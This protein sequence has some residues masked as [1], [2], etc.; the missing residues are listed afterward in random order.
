MLLMSTP[1]VSAS[2]WGATVNP[3]GLFSTARL[4]RDCFCVVT[5]LPALVEWLRRDLAQRGYDWRIIETHP[6]L[7]SELAVFVSRMHIERMQSL[8][9]AV[10][11]VVTNPGYIE[12]TLAQAPPIARIAPAQRGVFFGYDFHID[13]DGS[14]GG[15]DPQLIEINTNAGGA[16]LN[17]E[18]GRAQRAC[19]YAVGDCFIGS[20]DADHL[21]VDIVAMFRDEWRLARGD[22]PLKHIAIIDDT[23]TGQYLYP[24]FLLFA[25]LFELHGLR[26]VVADAAALEWD[27]TML[28][29]EGRQIDL[30]YNRLTDFHL[31]E[32]QHAAL[33]SAYLA[34][35]VVLTPHPRAYALY[36]DKRNLAL[37]T[38]AERM[39]E[40]RV[41]EEVVDTL[42]AGIPTT[43]VVR[44][45]DAESLWA[46]RK[47]LFFKPAY[48]FGSRGSYRG[49]KLTRGTFARVLEGN[50]VA[51][52][53]VRP[54]ERLAREGKEPRPLK[55]DLR[56]YVYDG[57]VQLVAARLYQ[58]QTTNFRTTGGG[59]A[60]VF[61]PRV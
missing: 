53:V 61:F 35:A 19:C 38:D 20:G 37:L 43:R 44:P 12:A 56:N 26:A 18:L 36:A 8:I 15:R 30:I 10:G 11:S 47:E 27:G 49:D 40:W 55:L 2:V 33:Q 60:P 34:G 14:A 13:G 42:L 50:Y 5:D 24:E 3:P 6:H 46:R 7:F 58:G 54:S 59:F 9:T 41:P 28:R 16:L 51:Q 45:A 52:D 22:A 57:K 32:P 23:P 4:N 25:R 29:H 48:G 31:A 21:E 17:V 39:R 1:I